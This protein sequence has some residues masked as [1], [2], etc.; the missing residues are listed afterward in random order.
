MAK[1]EKQDF[2]TFWHHIM[3]WELNLVNWVANIDEVA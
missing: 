1:S 2:I 3:G